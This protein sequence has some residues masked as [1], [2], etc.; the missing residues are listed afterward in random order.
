M[1]QPRMD[2]NSGF[3]NYDCKICSEVCPTGAIELIR[4]LKEKQ[5]IQM[6][7]AQFVEENCVVYT[8]GTD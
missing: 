7:K 5:T 2:Y 1:M 3:C 8:E 6:G 4:L